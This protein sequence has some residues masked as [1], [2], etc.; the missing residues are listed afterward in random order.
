MLT[1][2]RDDREAL[3]SGKAAWRMNEKDGMAKFRQIAGWLQQDYPDA[4]AA[5]REGLEESTAI[6]GPCRRSSM[7]RSPPP[8]RRWRRMAMNRR[9]QLSTAFRTPSPNAM[10]PL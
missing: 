10:T 4:A 7:D 8:G 3:I 5:L 2:W 9:Y 6:C 1:P